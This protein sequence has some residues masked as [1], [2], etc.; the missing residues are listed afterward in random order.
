M[1]LY[2]DVILPSIMV[3]GAIIG[4]SFIILIW[5]RPVFKKMPTK[6]VFCLEALFEILSILQLVPQIVHIMFDFD[7]FSTSGFSCKF[8]KIIEFMLPAITSYM[9]VI[10]SLE[11]ISMILFSKIGL[12]KKLA[13]KGSLI[14]AV[15]ALNLILYAVT[16]LLE[17]D[18]TEVSKETNGNFFFYYSNKT[19]EKN[20]FKIQL[21]NKQETISMRLTKI[22]FDLNHRYSV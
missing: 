19:L 21:I 18:L 12:F 6:L 17:Y 4:N 10:M 15:I 2:F 14:T 7:I 5:C 16:I 9:L 13:F 20:K 3:I 22:A 1:N 11:R 8:F